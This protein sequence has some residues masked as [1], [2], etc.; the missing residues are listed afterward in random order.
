MPEIGVGSGVIDANIQLAIS[1]VEVRE[2]G[3][4]LVQIT[5]VAGERLGTATGFSNSLRH[6][7]TVIN[8]ATG[9]DHMCTL[10]GQQPGD[11]LANTAT[12][13]ADQGN[14][15]RQIK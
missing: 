14:L 15:A 10:A 6:G 5:D 2:Q 11:L 12:G 8:L 4:D 9:Y 7:S 13:A 1:L 3:G